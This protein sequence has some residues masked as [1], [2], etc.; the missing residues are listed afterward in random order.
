MSKFLHLNFLPRS[1]DLAL[2]VLRL[3]FGLSLLLLHGWGKLMAFSSTTSTFPDPLGIGH[4][5]SLIL[6]ILGEVVCSSLVVVGLFTRFAAL[7]SLITM[8]V[9]FFLVHGHRL[10]GQSN[11][12]LAMVYGTVFLA[13]FFA[14][15]GRFAVDA[16]LGAK[17]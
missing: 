8:G 14:G 11:G 5:P 6:A 1:A 12:E 4:L 9:A 16:K 3:V 7:G 15:G 17:A 10:A 2:L 13:L